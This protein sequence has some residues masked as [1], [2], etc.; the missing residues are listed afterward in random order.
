MRNELTTVHF[1]GAELLAVRGDT[2]GTTMVAMKPIVEGMG[3]D[4]KTQHEKIA[5]HPVLSKGMGI[6]PIPSAGGVQEMTALPLNRVNFWLATIQ[7]DRI[8]DAVVRQNVI[9]YQEE[10]ADVL[11]AHFFSKAVAASSGDLTQD[12]RAAIGG[13]V[14]GIV[15]KSLEPLVARLSKIED[16]E[17]V[18]ANMKAELANVTAGYDPG[19]NV[20]TDYKPMVDILA[21]AGVD[22]RMKNFSK[23]CSDRMLRWFIANGRGDQVRE[24][25][26]TKRRL[27]RVDVARE[28]LAAEGRCQ[29]WPAQA[30]RFRGGGNPHPGSER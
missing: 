28:W 6:I 4:W 10:C 12:N 8:R 24:S 22:K 21:E 23:H 3:L 26:E 1:H 17:G 7:P 14:K 25:R 9:S 30:V 29:S 18:L 13:I 27:F 20:V 19:Q 2:P 16:I 15:S 11:F 5:R